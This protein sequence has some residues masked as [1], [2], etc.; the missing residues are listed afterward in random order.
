LC[1]LLLKHPLEQHHHVDLSWLVLHLLVHPLHVRFTTCVV[2]YGAGSSR[3]S[4]DDHRGPGR[5]DVEKKG[6]IKMG[7]EGIMDI[8]LQDVVEKLLMITDNDLWINNLGN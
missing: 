4:G 8:I 6:E 3:E 1:T 5:G 2:P 7:L